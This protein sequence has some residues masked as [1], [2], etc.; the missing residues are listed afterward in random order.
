M[1]DYY[2]RN[3][4][5]NYVHIRYIDNNFVIIGTNV[6]V[7]TSLPE[8]GIDGIDYILNKDGEF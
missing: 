5:G 2:I 1:K 7:V 3:A 4:E 8:T 6:S